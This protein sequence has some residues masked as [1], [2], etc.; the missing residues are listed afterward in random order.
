MVK[1]LPVKWGAC[2]HTIQPGYI[3]ALIC[4]K[5]LITVGL[6]DNIKIFHAAT[7][8][9]KSTLSGHSGSVNSLTISLDG[10]LLGSGSHDNT[11]KLWDIQTG[12]VVKT[13]YCHSDGACYNPHYG[14]ISSLS[15]SPDCNMI[16]SGC[17][18]GTIHLWDIQTGCCSH[19]IDG[20]KYSVTS[21]SFHPT[22]PQLLISTSYDNIQQWDI[23]GH[24]TGPTY[25]GHQV[26]FSI[27]GSCF[28]SWGGSVARVQNSDSGAVIVE[29]QASSDSFQ[30]CCLSPDKKFVAGS[31]GVTTYI[32][33]IT[34]SDP[35]LIETFITPDCIWFLTFSSSLIFLSE[36]GSINFW[37]INAPLTDPVTTNSELVPLASASIKS[38]TLH[39]NDG[40]VISSDSA[41]VVRTWDILTGFCKS[42]FYIPVQPFTLKYGTS[43][44]RLV[45]SRLVDGRLIL[46]WYTGSII[47]IWDAEKVEFL[48]TMEVPHNGYGA[49]QLRISG[50][51]SKVFLI[52]TQ[53][54]AWSI[55]T[56]EVAGEVGF[57]DWVGHTIVDGS[58]VCAYNRSSQFQWWD[59]GVTG[60]N[61]ILSLNTPLDRL[62]LDFSWQGTSPSRI[63]DTVTGQEVFWLSGRY[64]KPSDVQWDGQYLVVGYDSGEVLIM[65]FTHVT[66]SRGM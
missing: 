32:W 35:Y 9:C 40:I 19:V 29:L 24:R 7:G 63:R 65:D 58:K 34:S 41:G 47:N 51:G 38:V 26:V 2:S 13:F 46:A 10:M 3:T 57:E 23:N 48:Q 1:G 20:H 12:G 27:D 60:S 21:V 42:S 62:H 52:Y 11:I 43:D 66:P 61:P 17:S 14:W 15:I 54:R 44:S 33:D 50:D 6:T 22:N 36:D 53:I 45:D 4:W 16:A 30:Y 25:N 59:F 37:Q 49:S 28:L 31:A 56:G 5:D 64:A 18:D 8:I 55:W 39:T